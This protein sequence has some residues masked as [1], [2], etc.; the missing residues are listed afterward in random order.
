MIIHFDPKAMH[1][2]VICG[3]LEEYTPSDEVK[4]INLK[5]QA[6]KEQMEEFMTK[7]MNPQIAEISALIDQNN[8]KYTTNVK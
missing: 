8:K 4:E 5:V 1:V 7:T 2:Q 3:M 6:L